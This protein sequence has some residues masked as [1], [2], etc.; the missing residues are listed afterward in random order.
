M[1]SAIQ[2]TLLTNSKYYLIGKYKLNSN[3]NGLDYFSGLKTISIES[4]FVNNA[5][6][7]S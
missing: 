4:A 1:K 3:K 7:K 5:L 2:I 6:A